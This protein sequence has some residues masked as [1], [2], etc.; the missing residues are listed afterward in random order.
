MATA[1]D[2]PSEIAPTIVLADVRRVLR[3]SRHT[4]DRMCR[5]KEFPRPFKVGGLRRWLRADIE[6][7]IAERA[8][9]AQQSEGVDRG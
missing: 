1:P 2:A 7:W 6:K 4:V 8:A 9:A 5:R 3:V